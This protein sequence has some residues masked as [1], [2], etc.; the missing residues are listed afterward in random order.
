MFDFGIEGYRPQWLN[1]HS[2]LS[3]G[4]GRRL[5]GLIGRPLTR[6]WLVW[7]VRDDE[8]F[9]DCPVLL[10]FA[11]E[12][13]EI[14]HH[15]FDDLSVT[16]NTVD[17]HQPVLWPG[18]DLRWRH[19]THSELSAL[20]GHIL[21]DV[22]LLEWTGSDVAAGSVAVSFR[23]S[24]SRLTVANSLDENELTFG[25]PDAH[26][27]RHSVARSTSAEPGHLQG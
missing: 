18:F 1:S 10:D 2:D 22:E 6:V 3:A 5:R 9:S 4:H 13:V 7:D 25:P 23:F 26:H 20:Q 8:W 16:W 27:R 17:P 19:D 14:N 21:Q 24:H 12:Q 11:G 15:K